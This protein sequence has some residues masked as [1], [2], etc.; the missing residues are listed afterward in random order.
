MPSSKQQPSRGISRPDSNSRVYKPTAAEVAAFGRIAPSYLNGI[1]H[2]S[3]D[4]PVYANFSPEAVNRRYA[5]VLEA[6][7][8]FWNVPIDPADEWSLGELLKELE[9]WIGDELGET[10]LIGL[11]IDPV[12]SSSEISEYLSSGDQ[13]SRDVV[14]ELKLDMSEKGL[15]LDDRF[16]TISLYSK[17][18]AA[19]QFSDVYKKI[20]SVCPKL[21]KEWWSAMDFA[22][23]YYFT[24]VTPRSVHTM[25]SALNWGWEQDESERL[26][27]EI[28]Y[29]KE[30]AK[31]EKKS[32]KE[33]AEMIQ[34]IKEQVWTNEKL[35]K[36]FKGMPP[37]F[38]K[39]RWY[40]GKELI[41]QLAKHEDRLKMR[42]QD[43]PELDGWK[44]HFD[45][46]I[47][48]LEKL[49]DSTLDKPRFILSGGLSWCA[50]PLVIQWHEE[51]PTW[52]FLEQINENDQ[53]GGDVLMDT[54]YMDFYDNSRPESIEAAL[55]RLTIVMDYSKM[56]PAILHILPKVDNERSY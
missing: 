5:N 56:L 25:C 49:D 38:L 12:Y 34:E 43:V 17:N 23:N 51:D 24:T 14:K 16:G 36:S 22:L 31:R 4:F 11:G 18:F 44:Q 19:F 9:E 30:M 37:D 1:L 41:N 50:A 21:A 47:A 39:D 52:M 55:K 45:A 3:E 28:H 48:L 42:Y 40:A 35:R 29:A 2:F 15:D 53:N 13:S 7:G 54:F 27:E 46:L 33:L 6:L 32:K 10:S 20:E 26:E 8:K